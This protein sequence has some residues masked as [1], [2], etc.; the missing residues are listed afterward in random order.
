[1]IAAQKTEKV[2]LLRIH[3]AISD[4]WVEVATRAEAIER[5]EAIV[6][7]VGT[8]PSL[9]TSQTVYIIEAMKVTEEES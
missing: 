7:H 1:M 9:R 2:W 4:R 5:A 3:D 6:T 8:Y